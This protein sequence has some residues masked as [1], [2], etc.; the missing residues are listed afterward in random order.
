MFLLYFV[1]K[2]SL[3][4]FLTVILL[5]LSANALQ[6]PGTTWPR[7]I[8]NLDHEGF[9]IPNMEAFLFF[10]MVV[11]NICKVCYQTGSSS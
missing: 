10:M 2:R 7:V 1:I 6:A 9:D 3:F 8:E 4:V 5:L 11:R